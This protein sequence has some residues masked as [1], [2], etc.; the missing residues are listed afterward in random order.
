MINA[1][2]TQRVTVD[3]SNATINN[4]VSIPANDD[5]FKRN[6]LTCKKF[7]KRWCAAAAAAAMDQILDGCDWVMILK[8]NTVKKKNIL[9]LIFVNL[10]PVTHI[11][12]LYNLNGKNFSS[13][14][15]ACNSIPLSSFGTSSI[16][17]LKGMIA[18]LVVVIITNGN[19]AGTII[20]QSKLQ[21]IIS[22]A[23]TV[24]VGEM[25]DAFYNWFKNNTHSMTDP[26]TTYIYSPK[27]SQ[28]NAL[29]NLL[30][31]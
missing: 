5:T 25:E 30:R 22:T 16:T 4:K 11:K 24:P 17:R 27:D 18:F 15:V 2:I 21:L 6:T 23:S 8:V 19:V 14:Q 7:I 9:I 12:T 29:P 1:D 31:F 3:G 20:N 13:A 28:G 10:L 26:V